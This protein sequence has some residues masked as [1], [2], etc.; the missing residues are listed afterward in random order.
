MRTGAALSEHGLLNRRADGRS[1]RQQRRA[2]REAVGPGV[3]G[4]GREADSIFERIDGPTTSDSAGDTSPPELR[5][6]RRAYA[7]AQARGERRVEHA[8]G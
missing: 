3:P 7:C 1:H 6:H 4:R 5:A 8:H 2:V